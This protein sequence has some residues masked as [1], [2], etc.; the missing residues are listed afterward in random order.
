MKR[1]FIETAKCGITEGGMACGPV[2]GNV[3]VTVQ[4]KEGA[5]T[6]WLSLVEVEGIPNVY[7]SDKDIHE[8]LVAEDFDDE[9][10]TAYMDEHFI[11]EFNG[12]A[13]D[14]DYSTTFESI[15]DDP[16]NPAVPLIRYLI[17]LVRCS[18]DEVDDLIQIASG[19]YA[20]EL[21]IPASDVEEEFMDEYEDEDDVDIEVDLPEDLDRETLYRMR[22]ALETDVDTES[23]FHDM[24]DEAFD[25]EKAKLDA[26]KERCED[27]ADYQAWIKDYI[28]SEY[29]KIQGKKFLVCSYLFAGIGQYEAIIPAEQKESFICWI[30][31]NGSA[32]FGGER[33]ATE[34]EI[35]KYLALQADAGLN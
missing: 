31:G 15:A 23:V 33:E 17:T 4:F 13:F 14:A 7:L 8:A 12:I 6:Q 24:D 10:F 28:A 5:T 18:M 16:E 22:L 30:N 2:S 3:V 1:Y 29:D 19:K 32:F 9:E 20:D 27:E 25:A 26:V 21:D 35:K 34:D 11:N